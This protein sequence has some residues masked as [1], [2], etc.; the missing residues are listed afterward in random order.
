MM[1][2]KI[3]VKGDQYI[4][5]HIAVIFMTNWIYNLFYLFIDRFVGLISNKVDPKNNAQFATGEKVRPLV[6]FF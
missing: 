5:I 6:L 2:I 4:M 1:I 3:K